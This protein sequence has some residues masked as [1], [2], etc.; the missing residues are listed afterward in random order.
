M[1]KIIGRGVLLLDFQGNGPGTKFGYQLNADGIQFFHLGGDSAPM[2]LRAAVPNTLSTVV[3]TGYLILADLPASPNDAF[4]DVRFEA[5]NIGSGTEAFTLQVVESGAFAHSPQCHFSNLDLTF[6]CKRNALS[7]AAGQ[8]T[9]HFNAGV[10]KEGQVN[11]GNALTLKPGWDAARETLVFTAAAADKIQVDSIGVL[12]KLKIEIGADYDRWA[13]VQGL[14]TFEG[15]LVLGGADPSASGAIA[16]HDISGQSAPSLYF[17]GAEDFKQKKNAPPYGA[18]WTDKG[19]KFDGDGILASL[20]KIPNPLVGS[21]QK[22]ED[23]SIE[24]W[25]KPNQVLQ[26]GPALIFAIE[27]TPNTAPRSY[28]YVGQGPWTDGKHKKEDADPPGAW[29]N[30]SYGPPSTAVPVLKAPYWEK[31][32]E[33][34]ANTLA[35]ELMHVVYAYDQSGTQRIFINGVEVAEKYDPGYY[36]DWL[37]DLRLALGNSLRKGLGD[38][39]RNDKPWKGEVQ[40]L[41][42][43][44]RA[45]TAADVNQ[46]YRPVVRITGDLRLDHVI[47]PL[48]DKAFP[49]VLSLDWDNA[50]LTVAQEVDYNINQGLGFRYV[51]LNCTKQPDSPWA[52]AGEFQTRFWEDLVPLRANVSTAD[53]RLNLTS[54]E[55]LSPSALGEIALQVNNSDVWQLSFGKHQEYPVVP[56]VLEQSMPGY[57][58]F[59]LARPEITLAEPISMK[60]KWLEEEVEFVSRKTGANRFMKGS[61]GFSVPFTLLLPPHVDP[62]TGDVLGDPILLDQVD[63]LITLDVQLLK[64][65]FLGVL[66]AHFM[67]NGQDIVLPERR[68]YTPPASKMALLGD[69]LEEVKALDESLFAGHRKH[70]QDYYLDKNSDSLPVIYLSATKAPEK[71]VSAVLPR[72]FE[73][74]PAAVLK[75][76]STKPVFELGQTTTA[77]ASLKLNLNNIVDAESTRTAFDDLLKKAEADHSLDPGGMRVLQNRIAERLPL[78]FDQLLYYHYGWDVAQNYIDLHPGMRLRVDFQNYQFVH[79][80]EQ[81]A[82]NGFAGGGSIYVPVNSYTLDDG[83]QY[84]GFGPFLSRL[85]AGNRGDISRDG[86]GG[87]FDLVK[88]GSRKPFF[89]LFF[90]NEAIP[91]D[92]PERSVT[93]VGA[94]RWQDLPTEIPVTETAGQISFFFRDKATIIPEIQ[95]FVGN[96][97]MYVPVGTTMRQLIEKYANIPAASVSEPNLTAF[98]GRDRPRRLIHTGKDSAPAYRFL[99]VNTNSVEHNQDVFDLPLVKGDK[100]Y[101]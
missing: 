99:N 35:T 98:L 11:G 25:I 77:S 61:I 93:I 23:F 33:S 70:A 80:T 24:F 20:E 97:E 22:S 10:F 5:K 89:R 92:A 2:T 63:M 29:L 65:G 100:F 87:L 28:F 69:I 12:N 1:K 36:N 71:T 37:G 4:Y 21:I 74:G 15:G 52:F 14:Y 43:Y 55:P 49:S 18:T 40:Q 91:A 64:E 27:S 81:K 53:G 72:L 85:Q 96:R 44:N 16:T 38:D 9:L 67:F 83:S 13:R 17:E 86:A 3:G 46:H 56:L 57:R 48:K 41:A 51:Q 62:E 101:F 78:D 75:S 7:V 19:I 58:E 84:L 45:L 73:T 76:P 34:P 8:V 90:P 50:A 6:E 59:M 30:V 88:T 60:G 82:K 95:V 42:I 39:P 32:F 31:P 79:I 47:A 54:P 26:E 94:E 66:N 68:L